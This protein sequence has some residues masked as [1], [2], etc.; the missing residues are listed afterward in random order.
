M[1]Q[2]DLTVELFLGEMMMTSDVTIVVTAGRHPTLL[3]QY[4]SV[5]FKSPKKAIVALT[6]MRENEDITDSLSQFLAPY[7]DTSAVPTILDIPATFFVQKSKEGVADAAI[8]I[9]VED[10][11]GDTIVDA[12]F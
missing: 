11:Q 5:A 2:R 1:E 8:R 9:L 10:A 6:Y 3:E 4:Y 7:G 12:Q